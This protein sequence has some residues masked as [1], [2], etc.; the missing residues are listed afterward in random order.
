MIKRKANKSDQ[1]NMKR[2]YNLLLELIMAHQ[3]EIDPS[4]W[5]GPM[6]GALA[7]SAEKSDIP[8]ALLKKTIVECVEF[9]KY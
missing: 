8:F 9:Y 4:L 5:M 1:K 7:D 6:I 3:K 2:A